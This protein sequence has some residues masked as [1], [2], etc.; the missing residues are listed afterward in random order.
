MDTL[1]AQGTGNKPVDKPCAKTNS[2]T[3][4]PPTYFPFINVTAPQR[5]N[6]I[7]LKTL[8][9]QKVTAT[10][11]GRERG[12]EASNAAA[13]LTDY[14]RIAAIRYAVGWSVGRHLRRSRLRRSLGQ[15]TPSS[16]C[17]TLV[18]PVPRSA[19]GGIRFAPESPLTR[20]PGDSRG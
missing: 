11:E 13:I 2:H 4:Y 10:L 15:F 5:S 1:A 14:R 6:K 16:R 18:W 9:L 7:S 20:S 19:T 8:Y 3:A 17:H 12:L